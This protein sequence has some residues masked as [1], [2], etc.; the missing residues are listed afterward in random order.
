MQTKRARL[1][2][3]TADDLQHI[4][5]GEP[6]ETE[7]QPSTQQPVEHQLPVPRPEPEEAEIYSDSDRG[8]YTVPGC[9]YFDTQTRW[10][11]LL[12][13]THMKKRINAIFKGTST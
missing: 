5:F 12:F 1:V 13:G 9:A 3:D 11:S 2:A 8:M 4:L 6:D 10:M 7:V